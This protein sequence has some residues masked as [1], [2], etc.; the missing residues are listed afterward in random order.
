MESAMN[1]ITFSLI[2]SGW[3]LQEALD[4]PDD[5]E[6]LHVNV[7]YPVDGR[8]GIKSINITKMKDVQ[9]KRECYCVSYGP[10]LFE[11]YVRSIKT[12]KDD[13]K[14][15][16]ELVESVKSFVIQYLESLDVLSIQDGEEIVFD[17]AEVV[18]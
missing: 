13:I 3:T 10:F 9:N 2:I 17:E 12:L 4:L 6:T 16:H 7:E 8:F 18:A 14:G 15:Q 11:R 1:K 5:A